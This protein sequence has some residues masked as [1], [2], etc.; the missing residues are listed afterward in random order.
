MKNKNKI[1]NIKI[2]LFQIINKNL[3]KIKNDMIS[4][5]K[6]K[7]SKK[8]INVY[9]STIKKNKFLIKSLNNSKKIK[10]NKEFK[11]IIFFNEKNNINK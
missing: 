1:K 9:I 8:N 4:I 11:N 6:I 10:N 2:K 7:I 5:K 3:N